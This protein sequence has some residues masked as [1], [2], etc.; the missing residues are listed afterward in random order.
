M[1]FLY[2]KGQSAA[3]NNE[4]FEDAGL[5][6]TTPSTVTITTVNG[7]NGWIAKAGTNL[8][9]PQNIYSCIQSG[10]CSDTNNLLVNE[11]STN[12]GYIDPI[13]GASYP[14]YSVF[15]NGLNNGFSS[16]G[17]KCFGKW[18]VKINNQTAGAGI[19]QLTKSLTVTSSNAN[20]KYAFI[21]V[22]QDA[23]AGAHCCCNN[24]GFSVT[25]KDCLGNILATAS[26][27][28][29]SPNEGTGCTTI[30]PCTTG[31]II[32]FSNTSQPGWNYN[33]WKLDSI[34]LSAWIGNCIT[35]DV[36]AFDCTFSGHAGYA[37]FDA[38]CSP[39][40]STGVNVLSNK[41]NIKLYPN[42]NNGLFNL[43]ISQ[44]LKGGEIE[45]RNVLGQIVLR[46]EIKQGNNKINSQNL[47]KGIYTYS[48]L[49][50]KEV[51]NIGKVII[52]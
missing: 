11:I 25:F 14:I 1:S 15:G 2:I 26:Q 30:G 45:M 40:L 51:I 41:E 28:S 7:I 27:F 5:T 9:S 6:Y 48:I 42:P 44:S 46:E 39:L 12:T 18:F 37:Y 35:I 21:T 4:D 29:V 52:E 24:S 8:G 3:C 16:N 32:S 43:E 19:T 13:I 50:N 36:R 22:L 20:F 31:P 17:F 34:D 23:A 49:Q 47:M 10:C 33:K 38:Q